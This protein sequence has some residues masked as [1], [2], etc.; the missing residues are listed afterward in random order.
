MRG[1]PKKTR[2]IT[3]KRPFG[4]RKRTGSLH[5]SATAEL[6]GTAATGLTDMLLAESDILHA[7]GGDFERFSDH[8][9]VS[10]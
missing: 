2:K 5:R 10:F 8:F 6:P 9:Q 7:F 1:D 4:N 3:K